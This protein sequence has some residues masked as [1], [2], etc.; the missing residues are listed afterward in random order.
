MLS[1]SFSPTMHVS[2]QLFMYC[3]T[4]SKLHTFIF[5]LIF[6]PTVL[7]FPCFSLLQNPFFAILPKFYF[8]PTVQIKLHFPQ[9]FFLPF[10][11][12]KWRMTLKLLRL[13]Q[14]QFSRPMH[15]TR[16]RA[17]DWCYSF[18]EVAPL[19]PEKRP[20][21]LLFSGC[22]S[23]KAI[24]WSK[25]A[26]VQN[27]LNEKLVFH[28]IQTICKVGVFWKTRLIR[29]HTFF[30][31]PLGTETQIVRKME[32]MEIF[33]KR[34]RCLNEKCVLISIPFL[35]LH[36][37]AIFQVVFLVGYKQIVSKQTKVFL[38]IHCLFESTIFKKWPQA[39]W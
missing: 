14:P 37:W 33:G 12:I 38:P 9:I 20:G 35:S 8:Q 27:A 32:F 21:E 7:H 39:N 16:R 15:K 10:W 24:S 18:V 6:Q 23:I 22:C 2:K 26:A 36:I 30:N 25:L 4:N 31:E 3:A 19:R 17:H 1:W 5:R 13:L 29:F 28:K 11:S 34:R